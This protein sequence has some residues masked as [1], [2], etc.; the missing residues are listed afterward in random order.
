MPLA[1]QLVWTEFGQIPSKITGQGGEIR[2]V[3]FP[4]SRRAAHTTW[5]V[6]VERHV[7]E[8]SRNMIGPPQQFTVDHDTYAHTIRYAD[9]DKILRPARLAALQ[10]QMGQRA[11]PAGIFY[12]DGQ[13]GRGRQL[14]P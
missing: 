7:S 13:T 14:L 5:P 9:I 2:N 4:T 3:C 8:F 12:F 10:P 11:S 6:E 1:I